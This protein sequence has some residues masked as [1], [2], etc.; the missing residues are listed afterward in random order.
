M[1]RGAA[2]LPAPAPPRSPVEAPI[3]ASWGRDEAPP[4]EPRRIA[5]LYILPALVAYAAF[6]LAPL[7]HTAWLSFFHWDGVT[8]KT[9]AG[10]ANYRTLVSD[11][12][13]RNAFLHSVV[14]IVF[15]SIIPVALGLLLAAS[16]SRMRVRGLSLFRAILFLPQIVSLVVV[17]VIWRWIYAPDGPLNQVLSDVGLDAFSRAWL[18]DFT[19]ALPSIGLIGTWVTFGLCMVLLLAGVQK[20]PTSLYDAARVDGAGPIREFFAVTLPGLRN[21]LVVAFVITMIAA[22]RNF[23]LVFVTTQGGPGNETKV[24]ALEVYKI[25]RAHV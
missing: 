6:A 3:E 19:W 20:I 14:L 1:E 4:G 25:G 5:Y 2:T 17:A 13:I 8:P 7:V 18:G 22:L 21:E 15:Y 11:E 24:P 12:E 16:L 10:L 23:D 9:W